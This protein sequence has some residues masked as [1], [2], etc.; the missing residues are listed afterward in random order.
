MNQKVAF[1]AFVVVC[2]ILIVATCIPPEYFK[3]PSLWSFSSNTIDG[4]ESTT[5]KISHDDSVKI[6]SD[7]MKKQQGQQ[8]ESP[9][10]I[11]IY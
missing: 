10:D 5:E 8:G 2:I 1:I 6:I 9:S 11:D 3:W 7:I 4:E